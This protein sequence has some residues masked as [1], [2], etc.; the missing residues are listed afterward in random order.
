MDGIKQHAIKATEIFLERKGYEVISTGWS[1]PEGEV[2]VVA[3]DG[4]CVVFLEVTA[5]EGGFAESQAPRS[6]RESLAAR[7]PTS[8]SA[9][10]TSRSSSWAARGR[11]FA[12]TSTPFRRREPC[13]APCGKASDRS[14][15]AAGSLP[16][17]SGLR[18]MHR[19]CDAVSADGRRPR[20]SG[21]ANPL[22]FGSL[23]LRAPFDA[24][25]RS[26]SL[27]ASLTPP[28]TGATASHRSPSAG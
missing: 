23:S 25:Q 24:S 7:S 28:P 15:S 11:S 27:R 20:A 26:A 9:S 16:E 8:P 14:L 13:E 12:I 21:R 19:G 17:L 4:E 22:A 2:D 10:T 5:S 3:R 6:L 1:C 18:P